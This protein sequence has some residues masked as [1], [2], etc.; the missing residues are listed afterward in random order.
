MN[1]IS[2]VETIARLQS[3]NQ[4]LL[5]VLTK[6][7]RELLPYIENTF[8]YSNKIKP[9]LVKALEYSDDFNGLIEP[10]KICNNCN[11]NNPNNADFCCFC[12]SS[13]VITHMRQKGDSPDNATEP[14]IIIFIYYEFS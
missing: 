11:K 14:L 6:L 3:L 5:N 4:N 13:L 10:D 8:I 12:G 7:A 2:D 9:L 1:D